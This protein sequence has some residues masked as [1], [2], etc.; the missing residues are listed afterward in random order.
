[1][2]ANRT[3]R[4][5]YRNDSKL[6][7]IRHPMELFYAARILTVNNLSRLLLEIDRNLHRGKHC[8]ALHYL[9]EIKK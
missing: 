9:F 1:M 3:C 4:Q 2:E 8:E 6:M 7:Y 5:L